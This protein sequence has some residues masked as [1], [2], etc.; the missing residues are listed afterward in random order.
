MHQ[1][2]R[3]TGVP[4]LAWR[5]SWP[6]L[7]MSALAFLAGAVTVTW[8]AGF[9]R[10]FS[11]SVAV[12]VMK[13]GDAGPV[14]WFEDDASIFLK[15]APWRPVAVS[16][17]L[18]PPEGLPR[19]AQGATSARSRAVPS[20]L[21]VRIAPPGV[22]PQDL[23]VHGPTQVLIEVPRL[24]GVKDP[25]KIALTRQSG[26]G[27]VGIQDVRAR[28]PRG[29]PVWA[30]VVYAGFAGALLVCFAAR[31]RAEE[32]ARGSDRVSRPIVAAI[33]LVMTGLLVMTLRKPDAVLHPQLWAE[34]GAVFLR[35][36]L[37]LG[38]DAILTPYAGYLHVLPRLVAA[39]A[40]HLSAL[41][42]PWLFTAGAIVPVL[43]VGGL[44][45]SRRLPLTAAERLGCMLLV[46]LPPMPGEVLLN[47]TNS[48]WI[49]GFVLVLL[50][51]AKPAV[52][53][54]GFITDA[55]LITL[56]GLTGPASLVFAP[57]FVGRAIW[58][59]SKGTRVSAFFA[60]VT[61]ATQGMVLLTSGRL[62]IGE[63]APVDVVMARLGARLAALAGFAPSE[64]AGFLITSILLGIVVL[65]LVLLVLERVWP[66][67][68]ALAAGMV[69]FATV[70]LGARGVD[71]GLAVGG[72]RYFSL[73]IALVLWSGLL[74]WRPYRWLPL[75]VVAVVLWLSAPAFCVPA[76]RDLRWPTAAACL[77][78]Q[79]AC[80]VPINPEGW[81]IDL[82][83]R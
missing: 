28:Y 2:S 78:G 31:R 81:A 8:V 4:A 26:R 67:A 59:P 40:P 73:P 35:D 46:A 60:V 63:A 29:T 24:R 13:G 66:A 71:G 65:F 6:V 69:L 58:E 15:I 53:A 12:P 80:H 21:T 20:P 30:T 57:L 27:P 9:H 17:V 75:L 44:L 83:A 5:L 18:V 11:L 42:A 32:D 49:L 10:E 77:D 16:A 74:A 51:M 82:P 3:R 41:H 54:S 22:P 1:F 52:R 68:I 36:A 50:L 19:A 23:Q 38:P 39:G 33:G 47:L 25:D 72:E 37:L 56:S 79:K 64:D 34:D 7:A 76:L 61:A 55:G 62:S 43:L 48:Q 14:R 45:A 70:L